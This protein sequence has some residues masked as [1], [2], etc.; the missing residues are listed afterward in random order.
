[1]KTET[2]ISTNTFVSIF[3]SSIRVLFDWE[4]FKHEKWNVSL[5]VTKNLDDISNWYLPWNFDKSGKE[6]KYNQSNVH[7]MKLSSIY[8][9]F[10]KLT[11]KRRQQIQ[12]ISDIFIEM[13]KPIQIVVP[14]YSLP[15]KSQI[16]LDGNHRMSALMLTKV[17]F[18]L[19]IF[20]VSGPTDSS[21]LPE[22]KH[23]EKKSITETD[24]HLPSYKE[25]YSRE[26][27]YFDHD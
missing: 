16:F 24:E 6:R 9:L 7:P 8:E 14:T 11:K 18:T 25:T 23:W 13:R 3:S 4:R 19:I 1:M 5:S 17:E 12:S 21:I 22:L 15:D 26:D 2:K 27:I 20:S 10:P